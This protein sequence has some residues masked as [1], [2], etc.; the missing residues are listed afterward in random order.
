MIILLI[1]L[2]VFIKITRLFCWFFWQE[3]VNG[4]VAKTNIGF[5]KIIYLFLL[6]KWAIGRF[7]DAA[8]GESKS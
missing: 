3:A 8:T 4:M 7:R 5:L 1:L 6:V 2:R